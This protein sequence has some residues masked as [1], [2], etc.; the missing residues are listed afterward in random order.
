[1]IETLIFGG[2]TVVFVVGIAVVILLNLSAKTAEVMGD[3]ESAKEL[4]NVINKLT[5][6][7]K[8]HLKNINYINGPIRYPSTGD[9]G[10]GLWDED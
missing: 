2:L 3:K 10:R 1:M 9:I 7:E 4:E 5:D 6:E 8:P